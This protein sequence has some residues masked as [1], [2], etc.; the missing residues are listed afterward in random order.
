VIQ[1][2]Y[3]E[4]AATSNPSKRILLLHA[5][6]LANEWHQS[7]SIFDSARRVMAMETVQVPTG[8]LLDEL[9][10]QC[11]IIDELLKVLKALER[12]KG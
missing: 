6:R 11:R 8:V 12:L 4:A 10:N 5:A 3:Q 2:Y 7:Q 9:K 1:K